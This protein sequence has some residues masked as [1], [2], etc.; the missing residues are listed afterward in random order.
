[1]ILTKTLEIH[2]VRTRILNA[3][4]FVALQLIFSNGITSMMDIWPLAQTLQAFMS[5]LVRQLKNNVPNYR[6]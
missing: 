4:Y 1:M 3:E 2:A 6:K 5:S